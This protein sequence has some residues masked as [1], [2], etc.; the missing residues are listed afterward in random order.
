MLLSYHCALLFPRLVAYDR[1]N[2]LYIDQ[3]RAGTCQQS[4]HMP[5]ALT[6]LRT[7]LSI[8]QTIA[9][10]RYPQQKLDLPDTSSHRP[11]VRGEHQ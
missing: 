10:R 2:Q 8:H 11:V 9:F 1:C 5:R 3:L 6:C 7:Q 4:T